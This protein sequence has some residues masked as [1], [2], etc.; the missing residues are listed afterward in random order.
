MDQYH[1]RD[2]ISVTKL[3][4]WLEIINT[5][6]E[7]RVRLARIDDVDNFSALAIETIKKLTTSQ[8]KRQNGRN[9]SWDLVE[10]KINLIPEVLH[11][12]K[13]EHMFND[14][15]KALSKATA[16]NPL[17]SK[18]EPLSNN[19]DI[20]SP[21]Q[22]TDTP[23]YTCPICAKSFNR[24]KKLQAHVI[25]L[26]S[27]RDIEA[28]HDSDSGSDEDGNES[29]DSFSLE[30]EVRKTCKWSEMKRMG[31]KKNIP[32]STKNKKIESVNN[33]QVDNLVHPDYKRMF[34]SSLSK[35]AM[36]RQSA[37]RIQSATHRQPPSYEELGTMLAMHRQS[38]TQQP[39]YVEL[40]TKSA[41]HRQ[42]ASYIQSDTHR[43]QPTYVKLGT[44][45]STHRQPA[46]NVQSDTHGSL[47]NY[48]Q[49]GTHGL[50]ANE[51]KLS[52]LERHGQFELFNPEPELVCIKV[53]SESDD[54]NNNVENLENSA[55]NSNESTCMVNRAKPHFEQDRGNSEP[56][57]P[58]T[59]ERTK[60][61]TVINDDKTNEQNRPIPSDDTQ[62]DEANRIHQTNSLQ[63][64]KEMD[65]DV[66]DEIEDVDNDTTD[67]TYVET[68]DTGTDSD[69][70]DMNSN[71]YTQTST[72]IKYATKYNGQVPEEIKVYI[73]GKTT[74]KP[75][76]DK[77]SFTLDCNTCYRTLE[78]YEH[79]LIHLHG[80][81]KRDVDAIDEE[82]AIAKKF[83]TAQF[84]CKFCKEKEYLSE[85]SLK[86][87]ETYCDANT[88]VCRHCYRFTSDS[89]DEMKSHR[90]NNHNSNYACKLEVKR[91]CYGCNKTFNQSED[92]RYHNNFCNPTHMCGFCKDIMPSSLLFKHLRKC[93]KRG[94]FSVG[95]ASQPCPM[96]NKLFP[97]KMRDHL[98][99]CMLIPSRRSRK[100]L[101][102][103]RTCE[104]C[105]KVIGK[106]NGEPT[107]NLG[108]RF[109]DHLFT[110]HG[111]AD[112]T[113]DVCG[114][115]CPSKDRLDIHM[116]IHTG[117]MRFQCDLCGKKFRT[118]TSHT[119]HK[120]FHNNERKYA[121]EKC[122]ATFNSRSPLMRHMVIH[123]G[124]R[125]FKCDLCDK[126]FTQG[127]ALKRH[128]QN[129]H[130]K[131][132]AFK[133][134]QCGLSYSQKYP[135]T[136][137][138]KEKHGIE[139]TGKL[140]NKR[141]NYTRRNTSKSTK[142]P[143]RKRKRVKSDTDS[144]TT[145]T[146]STDE[147]DD[148]GDDVDD[149]E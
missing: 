67:Q 71:E 64:D 131:L 46:S 95:K 31:L 84:K 141:D 9:R 52:I 8:S 56:F 44:K 34:I 124:K 114:R 112:Y 137:H 103:T 107:K 62:E 77:G 76:N 106:T 41:T 100:K 87:H 57:T 111:I 19:V 69:N 36:H 26:H 51:E 85:A 5:W 13:E 113:C 149:S 127:P 133:C 38:A 101:D 92:S 23:T 98:K 118:H 82:I 49:L 81:L 96:C 91:K 40:G 79:F 68:D 125:D 22:T 15:D 99:K 60:T 80:N 53:E 105:G 25:S 66:S 134:E 128:K 123:S 74:K 30:D 146:T 18:K 58:S 54:S 17:H 135:L 11:P 109:K 73:D 50:P 121:C 115:K 143:T 119:Q 70:E 10:S 72:N 122:G 43:Q 110:A 3:T 86:H 144:D 116:T 42:S 93:K 130:E 89:Q 21:K 61:K 102:D 139:P 47:P 120:L 4:D 45:S 138:M 78:S 35:S 88:A 32:N 16:D 20:A 37:S 94:N 140:K 48:V 97:A 59:K 29:D 90:K 142:K 7:P 6:K 75:T 147:N 108:R 24:S 136:V 39:T 132:K 129:V 28:G 145:T 2:S 12:K 83:S 104:Y 14:V 65:S 63:N 55:S 33:R 27:K 148:D 117:E 1:H 126:T